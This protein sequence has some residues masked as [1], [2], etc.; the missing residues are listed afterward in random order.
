[1]ALNY[2]LPVD[3]GTPISSSYGPRWGTMHNGIDFAGSIGAPIYA[4]KSG[5]VVGSMPT[6]QSG[7]FGEYII[8]KHNDGHFTG[9]AHMSQ[10]M[11]YNGDKVTQGQQIGT[12]G[13]TGDSTGPHLH[14]SIQTGI[15]GPYKD[16]APFLSGATNPPVGE[17]ETNR[18]KGEVTMQCIYWKPSATNP[19]PSNAYYF[20][21]V[22]TVYIPSLD[23][24]SILKTIY[25]DNNGKDMPEY[26]WG[27]NAPWHVRLEAVAPNRK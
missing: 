1:M 18:T 12:I 19:N 27:N 14:F 3:N 13:S 8:I 26:K 20:N 11:K 4:S 22:D 23:T 5:D 9:Y 10:R 17:E 25:K 2:I 24:I 15:W 16:P 21:G 7:G 6:S